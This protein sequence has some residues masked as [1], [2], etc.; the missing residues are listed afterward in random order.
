[1]AWSRK[2]GT[3][4]QA[5]SV[6]VPTMYHRGVAEALLPLGVD[7]LIEKPLAPNVEDGRAIVEL[8]KKH[9][10]VLQVG[11]TERF[12][13]AYVALKKY[14]LTPAFIEVHRI[15]PMT[16]RSIDVGAVLDLMIH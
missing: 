3:S 13:P 15:S 9:G 5:A 12:N 11:H 6:A 14:Q 2:S 8:A 10:R 1:L 16:F 4:V 7:L